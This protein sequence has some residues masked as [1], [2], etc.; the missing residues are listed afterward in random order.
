MLHK[1][2]IFFEK[3]TKKKLHKQST[4]PTL[5]DKMIKSYTKWTFIF[6]NKQLNSYFWEEQKLKTDKEFA[7]KKLLSSN[8][9]SAKTKKTKKTI[10]CSLDLFVSKRRL[11][12]M[13]NIKKQNWRLEMKR[14]LEGRKRKFKRDDLKKFNMFSF[15]FCSCMF[16]KN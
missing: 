2:R 1:Y 14:S 3:Q 5:A 13:C 12:L 16:R 8:S 6:T 4:F 7:I 15:S 11:L 9:F 10:L